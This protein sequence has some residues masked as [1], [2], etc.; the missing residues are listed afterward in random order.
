MD[1]SSTSDLCYATAT[2][3]ARRIHDRE[4]SSTEVTEAFLTRIAAHN[5]KINA[6]AQLSQATRA[7]VRRKR[8]KRSQATRAGDLFTASR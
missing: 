1:A 8:T 6:I 2:E 7:H 5:D 3:V 4:I